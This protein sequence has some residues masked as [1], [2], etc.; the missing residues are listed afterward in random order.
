ML[1]EDLDDETEFFNV[2]FPPE[3]RLN[4]FLSPFVFSSMAAIP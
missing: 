3:E 1:L 2:N 4:F